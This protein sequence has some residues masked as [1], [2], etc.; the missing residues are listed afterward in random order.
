VKVLEEDD[1]FFIK[2]IEYHHENSSNNLQYQWFY[3]HTW[4]YWWIRHSASTQFLLQH[5][6]KSTNIRTVD[7]F[8]ASYSSDGVASKISVWICRPFR[9]I[10]NFIRL[11]YFDS[12]SLLPV[13]EQC[14]AFV[15]NILDIGSHRL[16]KKWHVLFVTF[17]L[18]KGI[19]GRSLEWRN[20][21][22]VEKNFLD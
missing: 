22:P 7:H 8:P 18:C 1:N 14:A 16:L 2:R 5:K 21:E 12:P 19:L 11:E 3:M 20:S 13:L 4:N 17:P 15:V 6:A 10:R 9:F